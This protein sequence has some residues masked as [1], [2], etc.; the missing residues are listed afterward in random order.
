MKLSGD[1]TA[2]R[3]VIFA[4][5]ASTCL[6]F[7]SPLPQ[8][9]KSLSLR[10][11]STRSTQ[12]GKPGTVTTPY[13]PSEVF[14]SEKESDDA[15]GWL[16]ATRENTESAPVKFTVEDIIRDINGNPLS[17]EYLAQAMGIEKV[18]SFECPKTDTFRGFMS[19]ACRIRLLPG[20]QTAFYKSVE[21][22][23]LDHAWEKKKSAPFKLS[24]DS[25]SYEVVAN[26]LS[27]EACQMMT[28]KTG[29]KIP[30]CY[31]AQLA[32]NHSDPIKSKFSFLL[33]D[34]PPSEGWYQQW[35]LTDIEE[36]QTSLTGLAKMHAFFWN[37]SFFWKNHPEASKELE[38]AVWKS[39]SY[40]QPKAQ[41]DD[42]CQSVAREWKVK[43]LK[44]ANELSS[45]DYWT[46]L[47][48]RLQSVAEECGRLAHPFSE[49]NEEH[50]KLS[51]LSAKYQKYRTLTHGDPKQANLFFRRDDSQSGH[52]QLGLID[53][54]W[55]GFGLAASDV[56]HFLTSAVHAK[57]LTN[58][59]EENLQRYYFD[60][61][62]KY[63]V[64]FGAFPNAQAASRGYTYETFVRQY[65]T[66]VLDLVRLVVAYTWSRFD[67]A[68][69]Q[70]DEE[71]C[72]RTMNKT[73]YN[74]CL[75]NVVWLMTRCDEILKSRDV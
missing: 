61:L 60:E 27:S 21:F 75:A 9:Q 47:G 72:A 17:N 70:G 36:C 48:E 42:Q 65:E 1:S 23:H 24:R 44:F 5:S 8:L 13:D 19:N 11:Y 30:K 67:E 20:G 34:L 3:L 4:G 69:E 58:G 68:V 18:E 62:Q 41:N 59:G 40:V 50:P 56:A 46:N 14:T 28:E 10:L 32:P 12:T 49:D 71:A 38:T 39:G 66:A 43:R 26:W 15:I 51:A 63:L 2:L 55:S 35:L 45:F 31:H 16:K 52:L 25:K 29:V 22:E 37:G 7:H 6:S 54:Q 73:S 64:E 74:K 33:E 53:F 57:Q